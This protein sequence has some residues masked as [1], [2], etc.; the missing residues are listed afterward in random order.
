[1]TDD[2]VMQ[3]GKEDQRQPLTEVINSVGIATNLYGE[4]DSPDTIAYDDPE[5]KLAKRKLLEEVQKNNKKIKSDSTEL[6]SNE[7]AVPAITSA[8]NVEKEIDLLRS[9]ESFSTID[10][11]PMINNIPSGGIV[12]SSTLSWQQQESSIIEEEQRSKTSMQTKNYVFCISG[13]KNRASLTDWILKLGG[14]VVDDDS[15]GNGFTHLICD[16]P[17]KTGKC[18]AAI[19]CGSWVLRE[20]FVAESQ[21]QGVWLTEDQYEWG[22]EAVRKPLGK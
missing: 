5:E 4:T 16:K 8:A 9:G 7:A 21:A 17:T 12:K 14:V 19:A 22:G 13:V 20:S 10:P 1:M 15:W 6:V 2:V 3:D 18:L 11:L